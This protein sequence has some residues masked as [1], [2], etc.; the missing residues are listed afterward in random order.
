ME[1]LN[2]VENNYFKSI[3][4]IVQHYLGFLGLF[5]NAKIIVKG[6]IANWNSY[7]HFNNERAKLL[8]RKLQE[9]KELVNK[10]SGK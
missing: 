5:S 9:G 6:D 7:Y 3:F 4:Y 1:P 10:F 8:E 2:K